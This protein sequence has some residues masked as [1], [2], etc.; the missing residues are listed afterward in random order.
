MRRS[1]KGVLHLIG[2]GLEQVRSLASKNSEAGGI[3][4]GEGGGGG[5]GEEIM[6]MSAT[7]ERGSNIELPSPKE[8]LR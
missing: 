4:G 5:G 1:G 8:R 2:V 6:L 3:G 7:Q